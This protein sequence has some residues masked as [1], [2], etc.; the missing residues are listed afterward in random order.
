M[1]KNI[2]FE[3]HGIRGNIFF[4]DDVDIYQQVF[5]IVNQYFVSKYGD[6]ISQSEFIEEDILF[7]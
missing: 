7:N 3:Y 1:D 4:S 5:E 2:N 6:G